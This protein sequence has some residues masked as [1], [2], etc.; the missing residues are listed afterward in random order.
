MSILHFIF[1]FLFFTD[2]GY[3]EMVARSTLAGTDVKELVVDGLLYPN[4]LTIDYVNQRLY[5]IDA[6]HDTINS[7]D[8]N[9]GQ[10]TKIFEGNLY[11][12]FDLDY[13]NGAIYWSDWL[14]NNIFGF[15]RN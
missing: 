8:Y 1:S 12:G 13:I 5:W 9:G 11:H 4:G 6:Y 7:V 3:K 14:W 2:W 15:R 10:K